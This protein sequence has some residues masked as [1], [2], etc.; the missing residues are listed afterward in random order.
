MKEFTISKGD[1]GFGSQFFGMLSG[2]AYSMKNPQEVYVH[3]PIKNIKLLDKPNPQNYDLLKANKIISNIVDKCNFRH[4]DDKNSEIKK[5]HSLENYIALN[6]GFDFYYDENFVQKIQQG[7]TINRPKDFEID[8]HHISIH[9]RRGPDIFGPE[10]NYRIIPLNIYSLLINKL[11]QIYPKSVIHIFSWTDLNLIL[12]K[13]QNN[14]IYHIANSG[15]FFWKISTEWFT[16]T[17]YL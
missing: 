15:E 6:G 7:Y 1:D 17:F 3:T 8:K 4:L 13:K 5:I 16:Q 14:I 11:T 9:I 12:T 2:M 10:I